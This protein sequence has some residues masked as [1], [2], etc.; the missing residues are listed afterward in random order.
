MLQGW[1]SVEEGGKSL[2][3]ACEELLEER[4]GAAFLSLFIAES[5]YLFLGSAVRD[6]RDTRDAVGILPRT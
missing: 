1:R 4:V 2:K 5:S 3:D 6:D